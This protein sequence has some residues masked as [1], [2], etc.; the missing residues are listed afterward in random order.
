MTEVPHTKKQGENVLP[1]F[2]FITAK[3]KKK[4]NLHIYN[5][6]PRRVSVSVCLLCIYPKTQFNA[7]PLDIFLAP[8]DGPPRQEKKEQWVS[9]KRSNLRARVDWAMGP[10]VD[11]FLDRFLMMGKWAKTDQNGKFHLSVPFFFFI[12]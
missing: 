6:L 7:A 12:D 10:R 11:L 3:A 9:D 4:K 2:F 5:T 1:D 8:M